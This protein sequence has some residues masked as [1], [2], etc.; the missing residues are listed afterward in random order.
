MQTSRRANALTALILSAERK[1]NDFHG[2]FWPR[3]KPPLLHSI[4]RRIDQQR[5]SADDFCVRDMAVCRNGDFNLDL[6][7]H[8]HLLGQRR[9][10]RR[11]PGSNLALAGL[12][13]IVLRRGL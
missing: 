2:F 13:R 7:R 9:I 4:E 10:F 12:R 11:D 6:A 8:V 5:T 3:F 1:L